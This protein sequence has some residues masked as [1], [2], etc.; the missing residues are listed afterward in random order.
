MSVNKEDRQD[1]QPT[2]LESKQNI[3]YYIMLQFYDDD[4]KH[5]ICDTQDDKWR[6]NNE[7]QWEACAAALTYII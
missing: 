7:Q 5:S 6:Q 2:S 3:H 1:W 4:R